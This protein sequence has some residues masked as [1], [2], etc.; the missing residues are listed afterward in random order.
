MNAETQHSRRDFLPIVIRPLAESDIPL[1]YATWLNSFAPHR[2]KSIPA[3]VFYERHHDAIEQRLKVSLETGGALAACSPDDQ[4]QVF[5]WA[6]GVPG[7]LDYVFVKSLYRR[8]GVGAELLRRYTNAFNV[9]THTTPSFRYMRAGGCV[10]L[11][12][13]YDPYHFLVEPKGS[14]Q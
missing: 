10:P 11:N 7:A 12:V 4:L 14:A 3:Q 2:D 8:L 13:A 1:V 6:V 5:G 9:F